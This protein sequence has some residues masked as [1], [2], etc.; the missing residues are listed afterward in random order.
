MVHTVVKLLTRTYQ[1]TPFSSQHR[2]RGYPTTNYT[3][4][5]AYMQFIIHNIHNKDI[6]KACDIQ[7]SW[8]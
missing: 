2:M 7:I 1:D 3:G 4:V 8:Y 5:Y 6:F